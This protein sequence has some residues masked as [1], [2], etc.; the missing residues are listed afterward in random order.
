MTLGPYI[1]QDPWVL[2]LLGVIPIYLLYYFLFVVR[3]KGK[4]KSSRFDAVPYSPSFWLHIPMICF[5]GGL[6]LFIIGLA[7]PQLNKESDTFYEQYAEGIDII[8]AMDISESMLEEDFDPNRLEASKEVAKEFIKSRK[9]DRMGLVVYEAESFTQCPLTSDQEVLLELLDDIQ[10]GIMAGG[11]AIGTGL[12]TAVNRLRESEAKSKVIVLLTDGVNNR[13]KIHPLSAADI[14]N[15]FGIR[16]YTIGV[17]TNGTIKKQVG[18]DIF[19]QEPIYNE[20][21]VEIDEEV[22]NEVANRTN[23]QYFRAVD[24]SSLEN[25]YREIDQLEKDIIKTVE[26]QVDI[27]EQFFN[28]VL[29]GLILFTTGLVLKQIV[30]RTTP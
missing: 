27:P 17:G 4:I 11:T 12:A 28:F 26:Y 6:G 16:V 24:K 20:F 23:G 8:I 30:F 13:G 25:I 5:L 22:L 2:T 15:E 9:N 21:T 29:M 10:P 14:A 7:R 1:F 19:T 3:R 18:Y